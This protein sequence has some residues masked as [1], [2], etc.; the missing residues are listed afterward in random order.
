MNILNE[1]ADIDQK[2]TSR[3]SIV[4]AAA[5]R[6]R[7]IVGGAEYKDMD[8][9]TDKAVSIAV[10]EIYK[11]HVRVIPKDGMKTWFDD[12]EIVVQNMPT[13]ID[14]SYAMTDEADF[15]EK[16]FD[17]IDDAAEEDDD[18]TDEEDSDE[19]DE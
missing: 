10:S 19:D 16:G 18:W 2:V 12:T 11:G 13:L 8:L 3:Y 4:I 17:D 5:K 15:D 1:K 6:A 7:Q 14:D 9:D